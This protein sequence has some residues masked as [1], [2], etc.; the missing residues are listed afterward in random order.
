MS[1]FYSIQRELARNTV[2]D[3]AYVGNRANKLLLFADFNQALPNPPGRVVPLQQRRP[4]A[5]FSDITYAFPG[6]WSN[7][8]SLQVRFERRYSDLFVL[9]SFTWSKAL[10]N[11]SGALEGPNGNAS[12][13]QNFYDLAAEKGP[14]AYDQKFTNVTSVVWQIPVGQGRRWLSSMPAAG[15]YILGG[16]QITGIHNAW[17]GQ[18]INLFYAAGGAFAVSGIGPDWRGAPR[19]RPNVT[20]DPTTPEAQRTHTNWLNRDTVVIPTDPSQ[21]FG[22]AGRNVA[23]GPAFYEVDMGFIKEFALP[24]E[25]MQLQFR[26]EI[27]NFLNKTNFNPTSNG[28]LANRSN[29]SFGRITGTHSP[30][31]V[32]F[33]LKLTF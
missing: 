8:N 3:I 6:S 28:N 16:W 12:A 7:Y 11:G 10:D 22:N 27:F 32:Q 19:M 33:A 20:G 5:S 26:T 25:G 9:N 13:P 21:P 23:R 17:S 15:E 14:S 18:P 2:L 24:R 29:A 1:W 30:R 4:I 31:Q